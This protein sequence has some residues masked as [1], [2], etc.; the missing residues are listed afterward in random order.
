MGSTGGEGPLR[1]RRWLPAL[2]VSVVALS[3]VAP[4]VGG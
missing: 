3:P 1:S 2:V 4:G